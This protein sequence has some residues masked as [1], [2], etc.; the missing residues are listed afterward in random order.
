MLID[1][2]YT[3]FKVFVGFLIAFGVFFVPVSWFEVAWDKIKDWSIKVFSKKQPDR[4][5]SIL[6]FSNMWGH[7]VRRDKNDYFY[8]SE[9]YD[10]EAPRYTFEHL[11]Y[12]GSTKIRHRGRKKLGLGP[13][14]DGNKAPFSRKHRIKNDIYGT[15]SVE[16]EKKGKGTVY[17]RN[18]KTD[19]IKELKFK[20]NDAEIANVERF[21]N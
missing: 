10:E 16:E 12:T 11:E 2:I 17:L 3:Y 19:D 21:F 14:L 20:A 9:N 15:S 13:I 18:I 6:L 8:I 5:V 1:P 7:V 4:E